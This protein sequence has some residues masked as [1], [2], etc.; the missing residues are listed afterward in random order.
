LSIATKLIHTKIVLNR[1][2]SRNINNLKKTQHFLNT[3]F[4]TNSTHRI[5]LA[6]L[7]LQNAKK[8]RPSLSKNHFLLLSPTFFT[9]FIINELKQSKKTQTL[10]LTRNLQTGI[11]KLVTRFLLL[12]KRNILGIKIIFSGK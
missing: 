7:F 2:S 5:E 1:Y 9:Q 10:N 11:L 8:K 4:F 6:N 12:F 3:A